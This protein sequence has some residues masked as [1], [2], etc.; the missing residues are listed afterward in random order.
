M[1]KIAQNRNKPFDCK[2]LWLNAA[3]QISRNI[4]SSRRWNTDSTFPTK[5][6]EELGGIS[7]Q[8][9]W[10]KL[11]NTSQSFDSTKFMSASYSMM[12]VSYNKTVYSSVVF[13]FV[14]FTDFVVVVFWCL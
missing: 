8:Y 14:V 7:I 13:P 3:E 5:S 2:S 4:D 10:R 1:E 12:F 11:E 6:V 9:P